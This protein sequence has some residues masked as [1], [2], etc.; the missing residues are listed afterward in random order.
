MPDAVDNLTEAALRPVAG[1]AMMHEAGR[2]LLDKCVLDV[3][4]A[5]EAMIA[6]WNA[7]DARHRRP[8]WRWALAGLLGVVSAWVLVDGVR[9]E[10]QYRQV[11]SRFWNLGLGKTGD[12]HEMF[13]QNLNGTAK[14]LLFGDLSK[15]TQSERLLALWHSAPRNPG[16]FAEYARAYLKDHGSHPPDFLE[17]ARQ[18]DPDNAWFTY[19]AAGSLAKNAVKS[20]SPNDRTP[21]AV[22]TWEIRDEAKLD[23]SLA[24]LREA[25]G[26]RQYIN[27]HRQLFEER[28]PM[29]P[30]SDRMSRIASFSYLG[31]QFD[32]AINWFALSKAIA[33]KAWLLGE[34]GDV[35]G[36]KQL[37][38]DAE[39]HIATAGRLEGSSLITVLVFKACATTMLRNLQPAA[40]KLGLA[41]E[42][43]RLKRINDRLEQ[44]RK[45]RDAREKRE[46]PRYQEEITRHGS[47]FDSSEVKIRHLVAFPPPIPDEDLKPGRMADHLL[48]ARGC[49][50]AV[51]MFLGI[52]LVLTTLF[53]FRARRVS[54]L[55]ARRINALLLPADWA[56]M[57][58]AGVVLPFGYVT[59]LTRF[60][61][62][63]GRDWS[64]RG[65]G[66]IL[67]TADFLALGLLMIAV[68]VLI[69][70]W[71]LGRR[72]AALGL[73]RENSL[74]GWLAVAVTAAFVPA[75]GMMDPAKAIPLDWF[76]FDLLFGVV[77]WNPGVVWQLG[78]LLP[79]ALW[80]AVTS[81]R[82]LLGTRARQLSRGAVALALI[83]VYACG[84]LL[85]MVSM[86]I[87][88]A[89]QTHWERCDPMTAI[90]ANG[91]TRYENALTR[92]FLQ[93]VRGMLELEAQP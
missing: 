91:V 63:G 93:D 89:A 51:W 18:L 70:R 21:K 88:K 25:S 13:G 6:R 57:L 23:Q 7:V 83:P 16:Y 85:L 32:L 41:E 50:L 17:T 80:I 49:S 61:A 36:F 90:T 64:L 52:C 2:E 30:Q 47:L 86:P 22:P 33:A 92:Q 46:D 14:F 77:D 31:G 34:A 75:L 59:V 1:N 15:Q 87:Y 72:A 39:T 11:C 5:A 56:W 38:G 65:L 12:E 3:P 40:E 62:L 67:P 66:L 28:I 37:L 24:L 48:V 35:E 4:A 82:A 45:D 71:R 19:A 78:L 9:E 54:L 74:W 55:L 76:K 60:T 81:M 26:Q 73:C 20:Q 53:R 10:R 43:T 68:P 84:M 44:W 79:L 29:L 8:L 27:R 69:V 42:A 58:G